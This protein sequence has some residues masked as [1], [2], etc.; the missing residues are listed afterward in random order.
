MNK[1]LSICIPTFNR[2][3]YIKQSLDILIPEAE[4]YNIAIY[5]SN[6]ASSDDTIQILLEYKYEYLFIKNQKT[7]IGIDKNMLEVIKLN[8]AKYYWLIGDDDII[9]PNSLG[10]LLKQINEKNPDIMI[11][12]AFFISENLNKI[13]N[14]LLNININEQYTDS[15]IFFAKYYDKT[16]CGVTIVK[17]DAL[18]DN[19][20]ERYIG[21]SHLYSG[22]IYD[23][24]AHKSS[25]VVIYA[26]Q[27]IYLRDC[28]KTW[29]DDSFEI[30][31]TQGLNWFKLLPTYYDHIKKI[32]L[33]E[34]N[35]IITSYSFLLDCI[36]KNI[37]NQNNYFKIDKS[38]IKNKI[39][40]IKLFIFM[41]NICFKIIRLIIKLCN[42]FIK[43]KNKIIKLFK[44]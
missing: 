35:K 30:F 43:L 23:Y 11:V 32:K 29:V 12:N 3:K 5:I 28:R 39:Y 21:T 42:K 16:P 14:S 10:N 33:Q 9:I 41:P 17:Q 38:L 4:V 2:A 18:S 13:D 26:K 19:N 8:K 20:I 1:S 7:N 36:N 27:V 22:L 15:R 31:Y 25:N 37:I 40:F 6:N 24:I 44:D 34:C